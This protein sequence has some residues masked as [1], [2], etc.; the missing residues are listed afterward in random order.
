MKRLIIL[1]LLIAT[2]CFGAE[3]S[4]KNLNV[5]NT[6]VVADG[7][8]YYMCNFRCAEPNTVLPNVK[9][10]T[11]VKSMVVN[12]LID[13]SNTFERSIYRPEP[14]PEIDSV[15]II[16]IKRIIQLQKYIKDN[17]GTVPLGS[18]EYEDLKNDYIN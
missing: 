14:D 5:T 9:N 6:N 15:E 12:C 18:Q 16:M 17:G 2:P 4:R 1:L 8:T 10:N 7:N 11:F 3:I 13:D